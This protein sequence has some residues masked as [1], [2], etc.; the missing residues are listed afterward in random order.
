[1]ESFQSDAAGAICCENKGRPET[2]GVRGREESRKWKGPDWRVGNSGS[3][4]K[5]MDWGEKSH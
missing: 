5:Q 4:E 1:M 3:I 2:T